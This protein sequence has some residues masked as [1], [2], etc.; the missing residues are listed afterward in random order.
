MSIAWRR[1]S[2]FGTLIRNTVTY[3]GLVVGVLL[4]AVF[5]GCER[6]ERAPAPRLD[7]TFS[8][9]TS[10]GRA[11]T[12]SLAQE[13][14]TVIGQGKLGDKVVGLS[15][16]TAPHGPLVIIAEDGT[17]ITGSI[18]LSPSGK[19]VTL[20]GLGE[21]ITLNRGGTPLPVTAGAFAGRYA[22]P[23][24]DGLRLDLEQS[25]DLLAGTGFVE[26]KPVAVAG[27]I[28]AANEARGSLLFSDQSRSGVRAV[29]SDDGQ[30]LSMR[31]LGGTLEMRRQ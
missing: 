4:A 16:I 1:R 18:T 9:A 5:V 20:T 14:N 15:A 31:G 2:S 3:R 21:P 17:S 11:V 12:I 24:S 10:D 26:G 27:R 23:G 7:G 6:P 25:G 19:N 29:L 30:T 28:T 8:G 13:E 22:T